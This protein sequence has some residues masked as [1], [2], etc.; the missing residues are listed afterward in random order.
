MMS[1]IT[2]AFHGLWTSV[3][4]TFS[5]WIVGIVVG[6][7]SS[8]GVSLDPDFETAVMTLITVISGALY[9]VL[10]RILE[11]FIPNFGWLIGSPKQPVYASPEAV[12]VVEGTATAANLIVGEDIGFSDPD[13][14]F[15]N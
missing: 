7:V 15:R 12:E 9:Y 4:R 1:R 5:P 13:N 8:L 14:G 2:D 3:V 6:W 11:R 10:V